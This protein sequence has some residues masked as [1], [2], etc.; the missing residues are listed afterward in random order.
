[1][2]ASVKFVL[3]LVKGNSSQPSLQLLKKL[4]ASC[5]AGCKWNLLFLS[6]ELVILQHLT[7]QA[8]ATKPASI[9]VIAKLG[10]CLG[11][12]VLTVGEGAAKDGDRCSLHGCGFHEGAA[13]SV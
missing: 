3:F 13:F 7:P 5:I 2:F 1:M 12:S 6:L 9:P 10:T 8:A 11:D 4:N